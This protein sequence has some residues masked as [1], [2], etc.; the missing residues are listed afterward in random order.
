[1]LTDGLRESRWL[2]ALLVEMT[3]VGEETGK[4][5]ETLEVVNEYYT[6]EVGVAVSRA[7]GILEPVIIFVMAALMVFILMAV[8]LPLFTMYGTV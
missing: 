7:L 2:P 5:E 4:M 8:Y 3:A 1:M 6:K